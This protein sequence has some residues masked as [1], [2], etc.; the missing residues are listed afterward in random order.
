MAGIHQLIPDAETLLRLEPE[1]LAPVLLQHLISN[2]QGV[3]SQRTIKRGNFFVPSA[4]PG[5]TYGS[6]RQR[7]DE[8]L[9]AAWIW[10]EREG[11]LLPAPYEHDRDWVFISE[12]GKRL[13]SEED[14]AAYRHAALLSNRT[15]HASLASNTFALFLRGH[16]DTVVF[17]AFRAWKL[18]SATPRR[19]CRKDFSEH[20]S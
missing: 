11:L 18:Q 9:S 8:A 12:R 2:Q 4:S 10:L 20:I 16:Y 6:Y 1:E 17:E 3:S 13:A 19:Y 14:F 15:L 5:S 7:V